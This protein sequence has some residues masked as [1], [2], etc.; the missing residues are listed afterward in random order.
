MINLNS[1]RLAWHDAYYSPWD[2]SGAQLEQLARLGRGIQ[3]T[4]RRSSCGRSV[5][6]ALAA[7]VQHAI[8]ALPEHLRAFGDH[9]YNPL[10]GSD[11]QEMAEEIVWRLARRALPRMTARKFD[12]ARYVARAVVLRYRRINQGGQGAGEDPLPS[13]CAMRRWVLDTCGVALVGDQWARDWGRFVDSCFSV[14]DR[15]DREA[16]GPVA[17]ALACMNAAA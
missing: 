5:H 6:Q 15:L 11:E 1:A 3:E 2:S 17:A 10:A 8:S 9:L 7:R 16:L 4:D 14:C 12:K 13:A